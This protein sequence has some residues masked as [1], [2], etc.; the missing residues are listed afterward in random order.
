MNLVLRLLSL[1]ITN[2]GSVTDDSSWAALRAKTPLSLPRKTVILRI[3]DAYFLQTN[4][5]FGP[6]DSRASLGFACCLH[7]LSTINF[8]S[9]S[10]IYASVARVYWIGFPDFAFCI[11]QYESLNFYYSKIW[12]KWYGCCHA[13]CHWRLKMRVFF[14]DLLPD[15][16]FVHSQKVLEKPGFYFWEWSIVYIILDFFWRRI[17]DERMTT[18]A[19]NHRLFPA[20]SL[21]PFLSLIF[22][23]IFNIWS[24][25]YYSITYF[26]NIIPKNDYNFFFFCSTPVPSYT[27]PRSDL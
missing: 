3:S 8:P 14:F 15:D 10:A 23:I 9:W 12:R 5:F 2:D 26:L 18:L 11:F 19:K 22:E 20:S 6:S 7:L 27:A 17:K 16:L 1:Q 25:I 4:D 24:N 21:D 13:P